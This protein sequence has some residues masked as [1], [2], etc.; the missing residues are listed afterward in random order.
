MEIS[1]ITKIT[2]GTTLELKNIQSNHM[3][4]NSTIYRLRT[5]LS[6]TFIRS[7]LLIIEIRKSL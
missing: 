7:T 3:F 2:V 6:N 5:Y 4:A 1:L